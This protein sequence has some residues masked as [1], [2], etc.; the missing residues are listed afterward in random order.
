[1]SA[2]RDAAGEPDKERFLQLWQAALVVQERLFPD[3]ADRHPR[4]LGTIALAL[5]E[6]IPVY[7]RGSDEA[8]LRTLTDDEILE[9]R[10]DRR[11]LVRSADLEC[12]LAALRFESPDAARASLTMRQSP[13]ADGSKERR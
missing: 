4:V 6:L 8:G 12:A 11:A 5:S 2:R 13:R 10:F 1:M 9:G 7:A 3:P